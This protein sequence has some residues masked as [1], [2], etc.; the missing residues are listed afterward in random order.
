MY[1]QLRVAHWQR[2]GVAHE[3]WW[4]VSD[5]RM[6][7]LSPE[8][9]LSY[10]SDLST[11]TIIHVPSHHSW[12]KIVLD[13][14]QVILKSQQTRALKSSNLFWFS[15][16]PLWQGHDA[17]AMAVW[18]VARYVRPRSVVVVE[19]LLRVLEG[20]ERIHRQEEKREKWFRG[21]CSKTKA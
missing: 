20:Q 10:F 13:D 15:L 16:V 12:K 19:Q 6:G 4:G 21:C 8:R 14:R 17:E 3:Q 9:S 7:R 5:T 11:Q 2:R 18:P 1:Q